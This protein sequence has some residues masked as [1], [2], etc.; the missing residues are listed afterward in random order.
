[1]WLSSQTATDEDKHDPPRKDIDE[2]NAYHKV[3]RQQSKYMPKIIDKQL[4]FCLC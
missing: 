4:K 2:G 3:V 1:V